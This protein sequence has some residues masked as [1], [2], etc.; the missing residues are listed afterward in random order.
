MKQHIYHIGSN[1]ISNCGKPERNVGNSRRNIHLM[2]DDNHR[3]IL[4]QPVLGWRACKRCA[5]AQG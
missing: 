2:S 5:A 4:A 3:N 1:G